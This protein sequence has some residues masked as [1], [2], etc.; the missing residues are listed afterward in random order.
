MSRL[1]YAQSSDIKARDFLTYRFDM[2]K[3]AIAELEALPWL[4][5]VLRRREKDNSIVV[6][7][8]GGDQHIWFAR[9]PRDISGEPDYIAHSQNSGN[10]RMYEFQYAESGNLPLF[11]FKL[12][13]VGRKIRGQRV[14]HPDREFVYIIKPEALALDEAGG[15][16]RFAFLTPSWI[17][18]NGEEG[19]VP[20]WGN[21]RAY[22]VE[23]STFLSQFQDG[24]DSLRE[25]LNAVAAKTRLLSYQHKFVDNEKTRFAHLLE[26]VVDDNELLNIAPKNLPDFYKVCFLLER[27]D[28]TPV[29]ASVWLVYLSTAHRN[30]VKDSFL[31]AQ[32]IFSLSFLYF[33]AGEISKNEREVL[34]DVLAWADNFV[35]GKITAGGLEC[36]S[37]NIAPAE[38][39]RHILFAVNLMEDITQDACHYFGLKLPEIKRIFQNLPAAQVDAY[40]Q[41]H[42]LYGQ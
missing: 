39:I 3:K 22:R 30:D 28:K 32:F 41:G 42:N 12:S 26:R 29:N 24:G 40:L 37:P 19:N 10:N 15:N 18:E 35:R 2:K 20:A 6:K 5:A 7:K 16:G 13:K 14:P 9:N 38:E 17:L 33:R 31:F 21:R 36:T 1:D 25:T 8:H 4:Q 23:R 27:M 34:V 11:D